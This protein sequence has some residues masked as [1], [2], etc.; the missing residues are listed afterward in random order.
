MRFDTYYAASDGNSGHPTFTWSWL[1]PGGPLTGS[2]SALTVDASDP[3]T[4]VRVAL[5]DWVALDPPDA[6]TSDDWDLGFREAAVEL[7]GGVSGPGGLTAASVA[8]PFA[9]VTEAPASGYVA[10]APL[11][12]ALDTAFAEDGLGGWTVVTPQ[13]FVIAR[14][15]GTHDKVGFTAPPQTLAFELA[16]LP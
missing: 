3:T 6:A 13:T 2:T 12:G 10:D 15:D 4:W 14:P 11:N 16:P 8:S 7:N 1:E 9:A 5:R